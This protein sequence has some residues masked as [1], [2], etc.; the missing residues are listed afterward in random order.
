M[1]AVI[2]PTLNDNI[3]AIASHDACTVLL[4]DLDIVSVSDIGQTGLHGH[5]SE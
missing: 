5:V 3:L 1:A 2:M 4:C